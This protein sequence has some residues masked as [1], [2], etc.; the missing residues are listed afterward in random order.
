MNRDAL[1]FSNEKKNKKEAWRK[2]AVIVRVVLFILGLLAAAG[3]AIAISDAK[4]GSAEKR[5]VQQIP[6]QYILEEDS[7]YLAHKAELDSLIAAI[8][9]QDSTIREL[10]YDYGDLA[11]EY[12]RHLEVYHSVY[13]PEGV[14]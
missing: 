8:Q 1:G 4:I 10:K 5:I 2:R 9:Q 12:Y 7:V 13:E 11:E 6:E 3:A 14:K